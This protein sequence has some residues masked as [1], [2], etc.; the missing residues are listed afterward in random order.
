[1]TNVR[2]VLQ[3]NH[4]AGARERVEDRIALRGVE[5]ADFHRSRHADFVA[6]PHA[7]EKRLE[8]V[9]AGVEH[10]RPS[11]CNLRLHGDIT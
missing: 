2:V 1:M 10:Q 3:A 8:P 9:E 5:A 4:Q 7:Q 6:G 11:D